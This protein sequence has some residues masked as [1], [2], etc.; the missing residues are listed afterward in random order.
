MKSKRVLI[1]IPH[2]GLGGTEHQTLSTAKALVAKDYKV[3]VLCLYR[4]NPSTV[5]SFQDIGVTVVLLSPQYNRYD[6]KIAYQKTIKLVWFIFRGLR[7]CISEFHPDIVHVQY[8]SPGTTVIL[9]LRYVFFKKNIIATA[10]TTA[11]IYKSVNYIRLLSKYALKAFI[12]ITEAAERSF[13]GSSQL[14]T[15]DTKL[16]KRGNHFTIYNNLPSYISVRSVPRTF[17]A[18]NVTIG[19]VS[20]LEHIKGMDLVIPAF[21]K[22]HAAHPSTRLLVVGGGSLREHMERQV[23]EAGLAG[24]VTF[25][26]RQPQDKLQD[27]YDKIDILL[28]PSRSEGFGLTAVEG[29]ARGC[30]VVASDTGGLPEVVVDGEA[31]LLHREEDIDDMADKV[32][33]LLVSPEK[34]QRLSSSAVCNT[35]RFSAESYNRL[36]T[37]L[38]SKF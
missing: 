20:R 33:S 5:A 4:C 19:V 18:A 35:E 11:D 16:K 15:A 27:F 37:N 26:G 17:D 22:I 25:A 31:G 36:I 6:I 38:Y 29:M 28:M 8:M 2:L 13:F 12:C 30:V 3:A 1:V 34:L 21:A 9:L 32:L 23:A 14:Y 7:K 10:H 24:C